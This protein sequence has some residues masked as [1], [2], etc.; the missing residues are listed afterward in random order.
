MSRRFAGWC[1]Y[2]VILCGAF[3]LPLRE[4]VAHAAHS[5]VHSY[6]LLIPFVTSYLI[7][8]R[9]N[10]LSRELTTSWR[11]AL[12]FAAFG[13]SALFAIQHFTDLGAN[14]RMTLIALS[15]VCFALAGVFLFLGS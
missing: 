15:F 13:T 12:L 3:A 14:D 5:D 2:L 11:R 10:H 4:F 7:Y 1:I 9:W 6:V 8:I